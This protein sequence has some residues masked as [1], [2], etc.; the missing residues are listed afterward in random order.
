VDAGLNAAA[1]M[2]RAERAADDGV[3]YVPQALHVS[4]SALQIN[5]Q[6]VARCDH[7]CTGNPLPPQKLH[8]VI[9]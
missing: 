1:R 9:Q 3:G 8:R 2:L 5:A 7:Y 6:R 4:A